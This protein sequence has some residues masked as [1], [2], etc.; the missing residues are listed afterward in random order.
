[1]DFHSSF[2]SARRVINIPIIPQVF[3]FFSRKE[4]VETDP[5]LAA[6]TE[7]GGVVLQ[8]AVI[9]GCEHGARN[10]NTSNF[11][12]SKTERERTRGQVVHASQGLSKRDPSTCTS[13]CVCVLKENVY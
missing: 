10:S 1:M 4:Y 2:S 3:F 13:I 5:P 12:H 6:H 9:F 8:V 7:L 11:N